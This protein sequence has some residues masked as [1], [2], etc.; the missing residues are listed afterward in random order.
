MTS[1]CKICL[2]G[3]V[4]IFTVALKVLALAHN[5]LDYRLNL[6]IPTINK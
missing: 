6:T 5:Y 1:I 4:R 2:L 3:A